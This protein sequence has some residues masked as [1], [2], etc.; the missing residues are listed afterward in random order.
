MTSVIDYHPPVPV[1]FLLNASASGF[2]CGNSF[3]LRFYIYIYAK[4]FLLCKVPLLFRNEVKVNFWGKLHDDR[5]MWS[6]NLRKQLFENTQDFF[7]HIV[8]IKV[9]FGWI[10]YSNKLH[11]MCR[12]PLKKL[13]DHFQITVKEKNNYF[14]IHHV[15]IV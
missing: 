14:K 5:V 13:Y 6:E 1:Y 11:K 3:L 4:I 12:Y 2:N 10:E 7:I 9:Y 15:L 8:S